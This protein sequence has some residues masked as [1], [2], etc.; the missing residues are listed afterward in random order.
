V[1]QSHSNTTKSRRDVWGS[2]TAFLI[3]AI[4]SSVGLG[5]IWKFPYEMGLHGGGTFLLVYVPCVL[6]V[7]FPLIM[8][9]LMIGRMGRGSPVHAIVNITQKQR[10]S[11][12]WVVIGWLGVLTSFLV[13]S[14]YSTVGGWILFYVMESVSGAFVDVPAEIVQNTYGALLNN[15][16]QMLILH[17]VFVLMVVVV[18]TRDVRRGLERA[19]RLLM[20][21]FLGILLW[22]CFY[23]SQVGDFEKAYDFMFSY[24]VSLINAELVISALAQA[25][26]SLSIGVGILIVFGSYLDAKRPLF[27]G[28]GVI[29]VFDTSIAL[30]MAL[31]IFSIVF[32]FGLQVDSG[33]GLVFETLPVAF[34]Q[35][36]QGSAL[37]SAAFFI[38]LLATALVSGFALLEPSITWLI[39]RFSMKRRYAAWLVGTLAWLSGLLSIYSFSDL[40]FQF[41][42]FGQERMNG[43][44][45]VLNIITTHVLMP[46]TALLV[47]LF[48]GCSLSKGDTQ[49][50]LDVRWALAYRMWRL[51]IKYIVPTILIVVLVLVLFYPA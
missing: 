24:D 19:I 4:G 37:L 42:Y 50:A 31:L 38:L 45:D 12:F 5:N 27:F 16:E 39:G 15:T 43:F 14:Y 9:E 32:A 11:S 28:V 10:L 23:A 48:A 6:L 29:A 3:A 1:S 44:F 18:L 46:L 22:L 7:A 49:E 13:F 21:A 20:P 34:S 17:T 41:Y 33:P 36:S 51:S 8:A 35:I 47:A 40:Q 2:Y 25:L 30:I 26:F